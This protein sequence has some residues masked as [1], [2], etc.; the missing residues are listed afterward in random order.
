MCCRITSFETNKPMLINDT[1]CDI[2]LPSPAEDRYIQ[3]QGFFRTHVNTAPFTGSLAVVQI[4]RM[5][6][7]LYQTLKSSMITPQTLQSF[8]L[9]FRNRAQQLPEAY[10]TGSTAPLET[11]ALPPLFTLLTAQYHLYR[12]NLSP[13]C[14]VTERREALR[15]CGIVAQETAKFISRALHNP[16]K[17]ELEKTWPARVAPMASNLTCM[18]LWRCIMVLCFRGDYDAALMCSHMLS[19]VGNMRKIGASCGKNLVFVLDRLL[20]RLRSGHGSPQQLEYDEEMLAYISGDAQASLE[21][22]WAWAGADLTSMK[23]PPATLYGAPQPL[24][25]D[26]PMRDRP[27]SV[28][29]AQEWEGW[30][31]VDQLIRQLTEDSRPRTAQPPTYYPPPHNPVKRVQLGPNDQSSPK[32]APLPSPAQSNA[33][34]ISIANII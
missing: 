34:R 2:S 17:A 25:Q 12:R 4:T 7:Q 16:P 22:G 27:T 23:S 26:Q 33:S 10:Q 13:V 11:A 30:S 3:P 9:Q 20:D 28:S 18:H 8:D 24:G 15:Q 6:A 21:H 31:R 19:V 5:Y 32:P 1:D 29:P 14:H